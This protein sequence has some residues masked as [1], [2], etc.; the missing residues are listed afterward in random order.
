MKTSITKLKTSFLLISLTL[1]SVS[2]AKVVAKVTEVKGNVFAVLPDGK[3]VKVTPNYHLDEKSELL[4]EE[5]GSTT[6]YDFYDTTYHLN[7]ASHIKILD[8]SVHLKGGKVWIQS[9]RGS[10][11]LSIITANAFIN[12]WKS[13]FITSFDQISG[14]SQVMVVGGDLDVSNILDRNLKYSLTAGAFTV[15]DPDVNEGHPRQPTTIGPDSLSKALAEF[16]T[17]PKTILEKAAPVSK[18]ANFVKRGIASVEEVPTPKKGEITFI[19]TNRAPASV[20]TKRPSKI[21]SGTKY[22]PAPI[23]VIGVPTAVTPKVVVPTLPKVEALRVPASSQPV[24][25]IQDVD[26]NKSL[27]SAIDKQPKYPSEV[28]KLVDDLKSF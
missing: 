27:E 2:F 13:E 7:E 4:V 1:S 12:Y 26:F 3:T 22:G 9:T 14:K 24:K 19:K 17:I 23:R 5:G 18:E 8:K 6:F 21:S 15:I 20:E 11:P 10:S 28:Q 16:K 25:M